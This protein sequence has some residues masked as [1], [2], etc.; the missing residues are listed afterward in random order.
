[1]DPSI[2]RQ[3]FGRRQAEMTANW[4]EGVKRREGDVDAYI[5][6]RQKAYLD[7]WKEAGRFI[8]YG[9]KVLDVGAGNLYPALF[10][11]FNSKRMNYYAVDVD[12][13]VVNSS[14]VLGAQFGFDEK[15]FALGFND[16]LSFPS[17]EFDAIFSS[18]CIEHSFNLS[19]TF[20]EA[21]RILKMGGHLLMAVPLG[22]ETNPEHPYFLGPDHWIALVED[23]GFEVRVAQIGREYP[24]SGYDYFIAGKKIQ[25]ASKKCRVDAD[26]FR[27]DAYSF[28]SFENQCITYSGNMTKTP[29]EDA[30]HLRGVDWSITIDLPVETQEVLPIFHKHGWSATVEVE[31]AY[32]RSWHDLFSWFPYVQPIRHLTRSQSAIPLQITIR[33]AGQNDSSWSTECVLYGIMYR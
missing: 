15:R 9:A 21:N 23:N 4:Y 29:V 1:M 13:S 8:P 5:A 11:Y 12:E 7:R 19:R 10:E 22:W 26:S 6:K 17:E 14:R 16:Q 20:S 33:P 3:E 27:K 31:S 24:E 30:A 2:E 25:T 18:H 32:S 28:L